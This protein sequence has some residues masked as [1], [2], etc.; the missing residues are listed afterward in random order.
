VSA[1]QILGDVQ[2]L[3]WRLQRLPEKDKPRNGNV[4]GQS[5]T[6][7]A[8]EAEIRALSDRYKTLTRGDDS[9]YHREPLATASAA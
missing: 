8:L 5:P 7:T 6:Y 4:S 2:R 1:D 9:Q 3:Y